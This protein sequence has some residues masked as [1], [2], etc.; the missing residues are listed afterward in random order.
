MRVS[1]RLL[2]MLYFPLR[3]LIVFSGGAA[4]IAIVVL[5]WYMCI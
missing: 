4:M 1:A 2:T 3:F 5:V